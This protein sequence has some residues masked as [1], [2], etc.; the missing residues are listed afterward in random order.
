MPLWL[1]YH[2]E[3]TFTSDAKE[4]LAAEITSIYTAVGLPAFYVVIN[5]ISLPNSS[6]FVGGRNPP[7]EKPFIRFSV[8]HIAVHLGGD[9]KRQ[10]GITARIETKLKPHIADRGYDYEF[11]VDE[12]P[13]ELWR[14]NGF[15]PPPLTSV[16]RRTRDD[17]PDFEIRVV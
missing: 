1:I 14:I 17:K 11:H 3:G 6:I 16:G 8:D 9:V 2:P 5:F 7:P 13:R 4:A 10:A 15:I 12:T